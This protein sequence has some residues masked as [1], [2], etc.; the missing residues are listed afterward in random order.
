MYDKYQ[1]A[2]AEVVKLKVSENGSE[3]AMQIDLCDDCRLR[4][5]IGDSLKKGIVEEGRYFETG[6]E[7]WKWRGVVTEVEVGTRRW[8]W[9]CWECGNWLLTGIDEWKETG[10]QMTYLG[11]DCWVLLRS[12]EMVLWLGVEIDEP[13]GRRSARYDRKKIVVVGRFEV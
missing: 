1:R 10:K 7:D 8:M 3:T 13:A 5:W 6:V 9:E 4:R 11:E 2:A 12:F